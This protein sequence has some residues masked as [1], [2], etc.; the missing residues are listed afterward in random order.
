MTKRK[1][2]KPRARPSKAAQRATTAI[3][4]RAPAMLDVEKARE[5]LDRSRDVSEILEIRDAA[6]LFAEYQRIRGASVGSVNDALELALRAQRKF[7]VY[8]VEAGPKQGRPKKDGSADHFTLADLGV[9]KT[10]SARCKKLAKASDEVFE[11]HIAS[12]QA[13]GERLTM[14]GMIAAT[15]DAKDYDGDEW[16]TP[17]EYIALAREAL[18]TID[19]DPASNEHA[20]TVVLAETYLTKAEDGLRQDWSGKVWLNPPYSHPLVEQFTGR[21]LAQ[22]EEGDVEAALCL[23]N[24]ATDTAW[25]Q[26][27][28]ARCVAACF[29]KTRIPF[30]DATGRP[31]KGTRQGQVFFYFG[32]DPEG[33]EVVFADV[34]AVMTPNAGG[35]A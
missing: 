17:P 32:E 19:F 4:K 18:G 7:G 34:G 35:G 13:K 21:L 24:N 12:V 25:C 22:Y 14:S 27:L 2:T 28:L 29:V 30:L 5:L 23:V 16:G 26:E 1:L 10:E 6:K 15:S 33:F 3:E 31:V 8:L 20:Q 9:S 11:H